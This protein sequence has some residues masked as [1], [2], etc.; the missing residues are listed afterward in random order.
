M[1]D[2]DAAVNYLMRVVRRFLKGRAT[3]SELRAAYR[4]ATAAQRSLQL[5]R[6]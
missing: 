6:E 5:N 1:S 3:S 2:F 4:A